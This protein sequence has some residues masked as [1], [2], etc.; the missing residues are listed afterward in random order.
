MAVAAAVPV[1]ELVEMP[2]TDGTERGVTVGVPAREEHAE[3]PAALPLTPPT[4]PGRCAEAA[5]AATTVAPEM[6]GGSGCGCGLRTYPQPPF[7][8]KTARLARSGASLVWKLSATICMHMHTHT[9]GQGGVARGGW[10]S[11]ETGMGDGW[12]TAGL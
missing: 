10:A 11:G 1:P 4:A 12:S 5:A 6:S 9:D 2:P 3:L 8:V 7:C